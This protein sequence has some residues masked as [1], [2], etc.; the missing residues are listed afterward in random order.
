MNHSCYAVCVC[1]AVCMQCLFAVPG[2]VLWWQ[3]RQGMLLAAAGRGAQQVQAV[4]AVGEQA[5]DSPHGGF[6]E[7][8]QWAGRGQGQRD[9]C[10]VSIQDPGRMPAAPSS[11]LLLP[12]QPMRAEPR[13]TRLTLREVRL[14]LPGRMCSYAGRLSR[15]A[16]H[17]RC[18][19][20]ATAELPLLL[21][22]LVAVPAG[23][24]PSLPNACCLDTKRRWASAA[25]GCGSQWW[26]AR[27]SA[28]QP[29]VRMCC[30]HP[31]LGDRQTPRHACL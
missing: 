22:F 20:V 11:T 19:Q 7:L 25:E 28:A 15:V 30:M 23:K 13:E 16:S 24:L 8:Q 17:R 4:A 2:P 9:A 21:A 31:M 29:C 26:A 3:Q 27:S 6:G 10:S 1:Y 18:C 5:A 12:P 14:Q